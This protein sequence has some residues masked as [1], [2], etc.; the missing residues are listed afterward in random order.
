MLE[1][2]PSF[3]IGSFNSVISPGLGI[4]VDLVFLNKHRLPIYKLG[5]SATF[6]ALGEYENLQFKN[7]YAATSLDLR[8]MKN[9]TPKTVKPLW[10]GFLFGRLRTGDI[11][12][13]AGQKPSLHD[14]IKFGIAAE[15]GSVAVDYSFIPA[16]S[17]QASLRNITFRFRF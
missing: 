2:Y 8:L 7:V 6:Y 3:G 16:T 11:Q 9:L 17:T 4:H 5:S 1:L 15:I 10:L 12:D 14:R 13:A